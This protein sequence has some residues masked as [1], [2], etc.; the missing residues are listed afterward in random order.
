[1]AAAS[2]AQRRAGDLASLS[3]TAC[4]SSLELLSSGGTCPHSPESLSMDGLLC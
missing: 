1:M 4:K 3:S 2:A